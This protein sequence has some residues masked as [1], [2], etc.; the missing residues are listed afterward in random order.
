MKL[1]ESKTKIR[2]PVLKKPNFVLW[3]P[4]GN[5][6][7]L[8]SVIQSQVDASVLQL[9]SP[10]HHNTSPGS[11]STRLFHVEIWLFATFAPSCSYLITFTSGEF[12][13]TI[14]SLIMSASSSDLSKSMQP[15]DWALA[16]IIL[17]ISAKDSGKFSFGGTHNSPLIDKVKSPPVIFIFH[18][19]G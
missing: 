3:K 19:D 9:V 15:Q 16:T 14:T 2:W 7:V 6:T 1:H 10:R 5:Q 13:R 4:S 18:A 8:Y 17:H 11:F 12:I